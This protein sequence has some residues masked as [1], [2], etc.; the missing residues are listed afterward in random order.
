MCI[1]LHSLASPENQICFTSKILLKFV[2][3]TAVNVKGAAFLRVTPFILVEIYQ[4]LMKTLVLTVR[5]EECPEDGNSRFL[6]HAHFCQAT[7]FILEGGN[8]H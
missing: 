4:P 8:L 3:I 1:Y 5:V 2:V 7:R 6:C